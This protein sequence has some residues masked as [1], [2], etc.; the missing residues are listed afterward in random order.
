M[1]INKLVVAVTGT[2]GAGKSLFAK[3]LAGMAHR[4]RIIE[5]NDIVAKHGLYSGTDRFGSRIVKIGALNAALKREVR[6]SSG[7]VLVV[8]HLVPE[9]DAGQRITVVL[10]LKLKSL[11]MRLRRRHY[12]KG[13]IDENV[14]A[15]ALDYCGIKVAGKCK[16]VY[17]AESESDRRALMKYILAVYSGAARARPKSNSISKMGELLKL[18]SEGYGL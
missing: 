12:Q 9:L 13:K 6:N 4:A 7:L 18:I 17:E 2:P 11:I 3:Q 10:R 14:I 16:E 8:G 5:I 1:S 15:E